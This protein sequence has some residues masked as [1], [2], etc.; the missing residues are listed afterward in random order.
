MRPFGLAFLIVSWVT[1]LALLDDRRRISRL[2]FVV[3]VVA[4]FD[5]ASVFT[6]RTY[7][8]DEWFQITFGLQLLALAPPLWALRRRGFRIGRGFAPS[9]PAPALASAAGAQNLP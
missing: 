1:L 2:V 5:A 8:I 7:E 6:F 4:L 9:A 3:V